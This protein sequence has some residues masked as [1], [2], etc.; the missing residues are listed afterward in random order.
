MLAEIVSQSSS[1][2]GAELFVGFFGTCL[3]GSLLLLPEPTLKKLGV[4]GAGAV[5]PTLKVVPRL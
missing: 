4:G 3:C 1:G 2:V 5:D